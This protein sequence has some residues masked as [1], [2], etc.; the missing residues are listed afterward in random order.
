MGQPIQLR[1]QRQVLQIQVAAGVVAQLVLL[2]LLAV[3]VS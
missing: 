3:Q 1:R 2:V